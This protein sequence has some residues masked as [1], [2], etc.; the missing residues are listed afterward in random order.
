M[1]I[2]FETAQRM[3]QRQP[4]EAAIQAAREQLAANPKFWIEVLEYLDTLPSSTKF[5]GFAG[6]RL[7]SLCGRAITD[8]EWERLELVGY[9]VIPP[10]EPENDPGEVLELRNDTCRTTMSKLLPFTAAVLAV[11]AEHE[12]EHTD[13]YKVAERIAIDHLKET[14]DYYERLTKAGLGDYSAPPV[15]RW[16]MQPDG[17]FRIY[18]SDWTP[19]AGPNGEGWAPQVGYERIPTKNKYDMKLHRVAS[20][21]VV[22]A[23][24]DYETWSGAVDPVALAEAIGLNVG[25]HALP[26]SGSDGRRY[27]ELDLTPDERSELRVWLDRQLEL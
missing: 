17:N 15:K 6:E 19:W 14:P 22:E 12:L 25:F 1:N 9:L 21:I 20:D 10:Y 13:N 3:L 4:R 7:C 11:G 24:D 2:A 26:L 18:A 5:N 23:D 27:F 8:A 16:G